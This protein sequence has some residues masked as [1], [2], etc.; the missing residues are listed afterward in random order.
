MFKSLDAGDNWSA[1]N[2]GLTSTYLFALAIDPTTPSTLY[3]GSGGGGVFEL[4][5]GSVITLIP[6][7]D[8]VDE[9][10][11]FGKSVAIDGNLIVAGAPLD[12]GGGAVYPSHLEGNDVVPED[13]LSIPT[14][15]TGSQFGKSVAI[16]GDLLFVGAPGVA[17]TGDPHI[18]GVIY[19]RIADTWELLQ[20]LAGANDN[21]EGQF[22]A[23]GRI[24]GDLLVV[25]APLDDEGEVSGSGSGAVYLF[26][27]SGNLFLQIDKVKLT[28][29]NTGAR[30]GAAVDIF[31][32][33]VAVGAPGRVL[34]QV[35][36]GE[37]IVYEI[38]QGILV[39]S[40]STTGSQSGTDALFG[41]SVEISPDQLIVG[42]PGEES[43][44]GAIY[45]CT[46]GAT[47][48]E[49]ARL[50]G[51]GA[52]A[53]FGTSLSFDGESLVVGAPGFSPAG[54][55]GASAKG[56]ESTGAVFLYTGNHF[57]D[58]KRIDPLPGLQHRSPCRAFASSLARR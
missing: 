47:L 1:V 52:G 10:D 48:D 8:D 46:I 12:E 2:S 22:G 26:E 23:S 18:Q 14:G 17:L 20:T 28:S 6:T 38:D 31:D 32:G 30:F 11:R 39:E 57:E 42:A 21:S 53:G 3:A 44:R 5:Q 58:E 25:G 49:R 37:V 9:G 16:K 29:P 27:R 33:R 19:E 56:S 15:F 45:V 34:N 40:L 54:K 13:R 4:T 50:V 41:A 7:P 55:S 51:G 43:D 35:I 24:D 36:S